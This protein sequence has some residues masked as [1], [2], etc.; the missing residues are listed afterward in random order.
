MSAP[1]EQISANITATIRMD[2]ITA[3]GRE[4]NTSQIYEHMY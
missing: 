4:T 1:E 2:L 3:P